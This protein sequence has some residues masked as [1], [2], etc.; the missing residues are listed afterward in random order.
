MRYISILIISISCIF[1]ISAK[2]QVA[3]ANHG[4]ANQSKAEK[5]IRAAN[6]FQKKLSDNSVTLDQAIAKWRSAAGNPDV[7]SDPNS[8]AIALGSEGLLEI[9]K[10]NLQRADS[11]LGKS[12]PLFRSKLSK[13][14]FLVGFAELERSLHKDGF[15]MRAYDE[16][17]NTMDSVGALWEIEYYRFS[18]YAP[19]AYAI[20]ACFGMEHI[21]SSDTMFR[22][23]AVDLLNK[24]MKRH[25]T[26]ALGLMT[27]VALHRLSAMSD[28][29]YKYNI[30][31]LCSRKPELRDVADRFEKKFNE[32]K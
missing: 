23:K 22:K 11:L 8:F 29:D 13:S 2:A 16:I 26:D 17:V 20:D 19:Y 14:S 9:Q 27:I 31:L 6:D 21:A 12:M 5:A 25:P 15:A 28:E 32:G 4:S 18:G 1:T 3:F 7:Q 30:D 24:T 10:G